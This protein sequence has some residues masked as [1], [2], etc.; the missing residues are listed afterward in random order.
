MLLSSNRKDA[1]R[2]STI[3]AGDFRSAGSQSEDLRSAALQSAIP[4]RW[5]T[6]AGS[7]D[8]A[9]AA[10]YARQLAV[11]VEEQMREV[12]AELGMTVD[13]I[14]TAS[15]AKLKEDLKKRQAHVDAMCAIRCSPPPVPKPSTC[16]RAMP[17]VRPPSF[18]GISSGGLQPAP[19]SLAEPQNLDGT[20]NQPPLNLDRLGAALIPTDT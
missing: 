2:D 3:Y 20:G 11:E 7:I 10:R 12:A 19:G 15:T 14:L 5:A 8:R 6:V 4:R 18:L 1:L 16:S 13:P 9:E 17:Y